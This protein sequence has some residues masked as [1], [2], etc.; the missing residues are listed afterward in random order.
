MIKNA[1]DNLALELDKEDPSI[2]E[3]R[4]ASADLIKPEDSEIRY[5]SLFECTG[6][7]MLVVNEDMTVTMANHKLEEITGYTQTEIASGWKWTDVVV[8]DDLSRLTEYHNCRRK[9]PLSMPSEYEFS[10]IDRNGK[11]RNMFAHVDLIPGTSQT[12]VSLI[13]ITTRKVQ[14]NALQ[15]S[16]RRFMEIA[17]LLPGIICEMDASMNLTYANKMGLQTFGFSEQDFA[18]GINIRQLIPPVMK[19]KY[20]KD[21]FNM[22]HGDFGNPVQYKL[23]KKDK[24]TID[25]IINSAPILIDEKITGIRTCIID[26]TARVIAEENLRISEERFRTIFDCS[27]VGIALFDSTGSFT[28]MNESFRKIFRFKNPC[29]LKTKLR[30]LVSNDEEISRLLNSKEVVNVE[31]SCETDDGALHWFEWNFAPMEKTQN[32]I[33]GYLAQVQ[34]IT[35]RKA[36]L[37]EKLKKKHDALAKAEA[38]VSGLR[39]ELREKASFKNMVSRSPLMK[40]IFNTLPEIAITSAPVLVTGESGTGKELI[41]KSIHDLSLRKNKPFIAINCGALPDNLLESELFGYK[42]GAFT[43]AKKDKPGKFAIAEGGTLFLDEIGDI[44]TSMQVKLLRVLQEKTYEPLGATSSVQSNVRV[45]SATNKDLQMLVSEGVFRE[46]LFYRINVLRISLPSLNERRC[47]IP[48]LCD[49][50]IEKFNSRYD[51]KINSISREVMD[52]LL[53]YEYNGNIRELENIIEHAFV[54][55][56]EQCIEMD[57]LPS[58]FRQMVNNEKMKD[59]SKINNFDELERIYLKS[60]IEESGGCKLKAAER[61]GIHKAT[62]FRKIKKLGL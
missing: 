8:N 34:D 30:D 43:D 32:N 11:I 45:I 19:E 28:D 52:L 5:R 49:F 53:S 20:A 60:V 59:I 25:C 35:E 55:C 14:E 44:S 10:I 36:I 61:L 16:R 38:L 29:I 39:R 41:A 40:E 13:D 2:K 48:L 1:P 22:M 56:K 3:S 27:P 15:E 9:A 17:D 12:L 4:K 31:T 51:K 21:L 54:F 58:A 18:E 33:S 57:H 23:Y 50:F 6:T 26:I 42:S 46:D 7:A 47:D 37:E 24:S 62:L